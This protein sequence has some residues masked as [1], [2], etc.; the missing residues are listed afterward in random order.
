MTD[1]SKEA[2]HV[3]IVPFEGREVECYGVLN[4]D[5]NFEVVCEDEADDFIWCDGNPEGGSFATWEEAVQALQ[6]EVHSDILE[7]S[8]V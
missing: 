2:P 6:L 1:V 4:E 3:Y 8:A 5:S 7:I